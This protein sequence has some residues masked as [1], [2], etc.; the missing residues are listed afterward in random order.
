MTEPS[1]SPIRRS[2]RGRLAGALRVHTQKHIEASKQGTY[3]ARIVTLDP[4][5]AELGSSGLQL[6]EDN[7]ILSQWVRR[8]DYDYGLRVG[9][10]LIVTQMTN[11]EFVAHDVVSSNKID[12]GIDFP[13]RG[14][15]SL[16]SRN[17]H[18]IREL[19]VLEDGVPI[20]VIPV[21]NAMTSDG[22]PV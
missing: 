4:I 19:P 21:Y 20:G 11:A 6:N 13:N 9:D 2:A 5:Q 10:N 22:T 12:E 1:S 8:Y 17:G 7:L 16:T 14:T 15:V 3:I 18:I